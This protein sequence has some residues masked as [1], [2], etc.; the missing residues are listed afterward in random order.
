M[1]PPASATDE[2][3]R[4]SIAERVRISPIG[5]PLMLMEL[6]GHRVAWQEAARPLRKAWLK[7]GEADCPPSAYPKDRPHGPGPQKSRLPITS[8]I[9]QPSWLAT[10]LR[11]CRKVP[12]LGACGQEW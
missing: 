4:H 10:S 1:P 11:I 9:E 5:Q 6:L 12:T 3:L 7:A 2:R 8:S